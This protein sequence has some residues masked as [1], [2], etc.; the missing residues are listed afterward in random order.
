MNRITGILYISCFLVILNTACRQPQFFGH[1]DDYFRQVDNQINHSI[2]TSSV[3]PSVSKDR[4]NCIKGIPQR[5]IDTNVITDADYKQI[6]FT[7]YEKI[8]LPTGDRLLIIN[9]GC[10]TYNLTFRFETSR[11]G[12]DT[13]KIKFW[14]S[15]LAQLLGLVEPVIKSPVNIRQGINKIHSFIKQDTIPVN[16]NIPLTISHDSVD[17]EIIF[18]RA[19]VLADTAMRLDVTFSLKDYSP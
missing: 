1:E 10:S 8:I 19:K 15:T 12:T 14:Y 5:V 2:Q 11:F 6:D 18:E 13:G 9:W 17:S 7:G 16:F 3:E 4:E